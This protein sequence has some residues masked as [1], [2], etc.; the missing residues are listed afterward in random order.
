M[1]DIKF[2][3]MP[4]YTS[5]EDEG[6]IDPSVASENIKNTGD[7]IKSFEELGLKASLREACVRAGWLQPTPIQA[8]VIPHALAKRDIIALAQTGSGKTGAFVLP[9]LHAM[10]SEE[11]PLPTNGPYAVVMS[12]T[13]ELAV[14]IAEQFEG[15][16]LGLGCRCAVLVGGMDMMSQAVALAKHP[17]VIVATPGRL[18]D[19]LENT[20]GFHVR[21]LKWLVLDEADRLLAMDFEE[22]LNKVLRVVPKLRQTM[23]FSATMTGSVG[24]LQRASLQTPVK[25]ELSASKYSTVQ[26]L[27]QQ[28]CFLPS[29]LKDSY[30]A[31]LLG[32]VGSGSSSNA[33]ATIVFVNACRQA[34]RLAIMLRLL[35]FPAIPLHGQMTQAKRLGALSKFKAANQRT[36][37]S[38]SGAILV[39]TD[40][41]SRGLDIPAVD[42][43]LNYDLPQHAKDYIHRVGRTARAGRSGRAIA[44]VTQYDIEA[45]QRLEAAMGG[46]KLP[47]CSVDKSVVVGLEEKVSEA[48]RSALL[49]L[50]ELDEVRE[51]SKKPSKKARRPQ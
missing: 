26:G 2:T 11:T 12:P 16:G 39:A 10:M 25:I 35:G 18:V 6:A 48:Q 22:A 38:N 24:K 42:C 19:H 34:Q 30:L 13:R 21:T 28:Y 44:M 7:T 23:L 20:R 51:A 36:F 37:S 41:A 33:A 49:K 31:Y 46:I 29:R 43:V 14:Q 8:Q 45:Y 1:D 50:K 9:I 40:V 27:V 5:S 3:D 17:H 47:E 32:I 15:L 4:N